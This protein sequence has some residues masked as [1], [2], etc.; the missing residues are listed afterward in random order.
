MFI[1]IPS[2]NGAPHG[3]SVPKV[4][5]ARMSVIRALMLSCHLL[6]AASVS[7]TLGG[8]D[9]TSESTQSETD[10]GEKKK[11]LKR[12]DGEPANSAK[13]GQVENLDQSPPLIPR[14]V[15]AD[16][17]F[18]EPYGVARLTI[19][20]TS[21]SKWQPDQPI[22]VRAANERLLF[23][24][25]H[26]QSIGEGDELVIHFLFRGSDPLVVDVVSARCVLAEKHTI[27]VV[28][29]DFEHRTLFGDWW[30]H[31]TNQLVDG[32]SEELS[33]VGHDVVAILGRQLGLRTPQADNSNGE[34]SSVLEKQF[35]RTVGMLLGFESVRLAMMKDTS[36]VMTDDGP[37]VSGLPRPFRM[38]AVPIPHMAPGIEKIERMASYI[39]PEYFYLRCESL[40]NYLWMRNLVMGWGGSLD[41]MVATPVV[42][43]RI[44]ERIERQLCLDPS[45]AV[46]LDLDA[47]LED[48]AIVGG[49][50]YFANGAAVGVLM[51]AKNP[52]RIAA[53]LNEMRREIAAT[54]G[55]R[56]RTLTI[57]GKTISLYETADN[58]VRS[59]HA[60]SDN[61]HLVTN[62]SMLVQRF[63]NCEN[64]QNLA[65]LPEFS[66]ARSNFP[67]TRELTSF[68]YLSDPFFRNLTSPATRIEASRRQ[69]AVAELRQ[70]KLARLIFAAQGLDGDGSIANLIQHR[71]LRPEFA[72]R[73]DGAFPD[74]TQDG[75]MV[76][77]LRGGL[78]TF[79]PIADI[80]VTRAT[81]R[82]A[83]AYA[84]FT[85]NYRRQWAA[86][87]PVAVALHRHSGE[88]PR[89]EQVDLEIAIAPYA[90]DAYQF[91]A[92]RLAPSSNRRVKAPEADVL[93]LT[94]RLQGGTNYDVCVGLR[95]AIVP[96]RIENGTLIREGDFTDRTFADWQSYAAVT[97]ASTSGLQL[98][99]EFTK[100]LQSR[101]IDPPPNIDSTD[102]KQERPQNVLD[103]L[104][105]VIH[106]RRFALRTWLRLTRDAST[107]AQIRS[108]G[109]WTTMAPNNDLRSELSNELSLEQTSTPAQIQFG[110]AD[111]SQSKVCRYLHAVSWEAG[112]RLSGENAAW[113]NHFAT[114]TRLDLAETRDQVEELL[115]GEIRCPLGGTYEYRREGDT[116]Q[117]A[118]TAWG[119][120]SRF[121]ETAVPTNYRLPFL[122]WLRGL[123]LN[124]ELTA[125]TLTS[126]VELHVDPTVNVKTL[127]AADRTQFRISPDAIDDAVEAIER[128]QLFQR[129]RLYE[130]LLVSY[131]QLRLALDRI[132]P[133][134][135]WTIYLSVPPQS[136]R[137]DKDWKKLRSAAAKFQFVTTDHKYD[138]IT[139]AIG[140]AE[141]HS[142]LKECIASLTPGDAD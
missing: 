9:E 93:T 46:E 58:A 32:P 112:R 104:D 2:H 5:F 23:P 86:M 68:L 95:D 100:A 6:T 126:R 134:G 78:G 113:L 80:A 52:E 110:L 133:S 43:H 81:Y 13:S 94:T 61:C 114:T 24:C 21:D 73:A 34:Q 19:P 11:V 10:A 51:L 137:E 53:I 42:E 106:Y 115:G 22:S 7:T 71:L 49:D 44:R 88:D 65:T 98:L 117:L 97:P 8:Q 45:L 50:T 66:Y 75:Q 120:L 91:L 123:K 128:E 83:N 85:Q 82:E 1:R 47:S 48:F 119:C 77:S 89:N 28:T 136:P 96:F 102:E 118:S 101:E 127:P 109:M 36:A 35:E 56:H 76:D 33:D 26:V 67:L 108:V 84:E 105:N 70:L 140:F 29:D 79:L 30:T 142:R 130:R 18:G 15:R 62:S 55:A 40:K 99:G 3:H 39:P 54:G 64:G 139:N 12:S 116:T 25:H 63:L 4:C 74:F 90:R 129:D 41:Q 16:A 87:D 107:Y 38:R 111:I 125:T 124:F 69:R 37:A 103:V 59:F 122:A 138:V 131:G 57:S 132:D 27:S 60:V 14:L 121:D 72:K 135:A 92:R 141:T 20:I 31:C 17:M